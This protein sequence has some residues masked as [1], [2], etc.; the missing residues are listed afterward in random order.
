MNPQGF[1]DGSHNL[2]VEE[3]KTEAVNESNQI[4]LTETKD[5]R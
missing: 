3:T 5:K 1:C 4:F 2:P